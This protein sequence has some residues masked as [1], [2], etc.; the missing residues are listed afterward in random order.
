[1]C[2]ATGFTY[3]NHVDVEPHKYRTY[4]NFT[5]AK[6]ALQAGKFN[7]DE[8]AEERRIAGGAVKRESGRG[9]E[10]LITRLMD[11]GE[12]NEAAKESVD[13][14][15]HAW[16]TFGEEEEEEEEERELEDGEVSEASTYTAH[17]DSD[18]PKVTN[19]HATTT[20]FNLLDGCFDAAN[21]QLEVSFDDV[22]TAVEEKRD[23]F[24][25]S[26]QTFDST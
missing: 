10:N 21:T 1:V 24:K 3:S 7:V 15:I 19:D 8:M 25:V 4:V 18:S 13:P 20:P 12:K 16:K 11:A 6:Y 9:R 2:Y 22:E 23:P 14:R 5:T 26:C 17:S